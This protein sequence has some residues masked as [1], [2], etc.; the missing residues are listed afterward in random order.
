MPRR[1]LCSLIEQGSQYALTASWSLWI[2]KSNICR[3]KTISSN[4]CWRTF[5][6]R[7]SRNWGKKMKTQGNMAATALTYTKEV[8]RTASL[9]H[10]RRWVS[11]KLLSSMRAVGQDRALLVQERPTTV[12]WCLG[13]GQSWH[14]PHAAWSGSA[15]RLYDSRQYIRHA[16]DLFPAVQADVSAEGTLA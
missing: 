7:N 14:V 15:P 12:P 13:H 6:K 11:G 4:T 16:D 5:R 1:S 3:L 8:V 10:L 2:Q 9:S